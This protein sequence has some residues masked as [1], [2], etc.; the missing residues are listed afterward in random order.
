MRP[1]FPRFRGGIIG[2][3]LG[4]LMT[5]GAAPATTDRPPLDWLRKSARPFATCEPGGADHDLASLRAIVGDAR[6]VA[7]GEVSNGTHEFFQMKRRVV[8]YLATHMGFTLFAI[9]A[10]MPE[11]YRVNEYV[12]TGRGDPKALLL[13]IS[14][15][16]NAR[17]FLDFIEWMRAFNRSGRGRIQFFG[18]D[19]QTP[20]DSAAAVVTRFVARA[21][22]AYFDSVTRAYRLVAT[23]P[24]QENS[25]AAARAS[26]PVS[27]A[28]GH[29]VRF[30][31]WIHTTN[32]HDGSAVLWWRADAGA[33]K[34]V[35]SESTREVSGT[36]PWTPYDLN[37]DI[38]A[39]TTVIV[40]GCILS[41]SGTAWFDSLAVEIDGTP[42]AG[43][44]ELDLSMER[45]DRPV[46]FT[47]SQ[48]A[49]SSYAIDLDSTTVFAGRRSLRIRRVAPDAPP[50]TATWPE[51]DSASIR[52]LKHLEA[53]RSQFASSLTPA[54]VD[55]A[56]LNARTIAQMSGVNGGTRR[57]EAT[58]AEN[59]TGILD[60]APPGSKMVLWAGNLRVAR[61]VSL[62]AH[63]ASKYGRELVVIGFAFHEGRYTAVAEVDRPGANDAKPS[64]PGS[65]E[66]A[67]HSTGIPRFILDL[68]T[69][70]SDTLAAA[71]LAQPL[72]MRNFVFRAIPD[73]IFV[74]QYFDALIY[75]DHTT[76]STPLP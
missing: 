5:C 64:A 54:D 31:G 20:T 16:R 65:L 3:A 29:K 36:T 1:A 66:W 74:G 67:C 43:N 30:S 7:L 10:N 52:V 55:W 57:R 32:V 40:F 42:F 39:N 56:I 12:L 14:Q 2:L 61:G 6:I 62:G 46:G 17:E 4:A 9:E 34:G 37:V 27:V 53:G 75:F 19:M 51:A 76:P 48:V 63:L 73:T 38:P 47:T 24:R 70:A 8:E 71:W 69:A 60:G 23:A 59:I 15:S 72:A 11:A 45:A 44:T 26:F 50:S 49:G 58:M 41:G 18:F 25:M 33:R 22:P 35:V 13:G 21:E 68:R 28:A